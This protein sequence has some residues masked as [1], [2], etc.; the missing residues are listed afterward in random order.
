M[1]ILFISYYNPLGQGGFEKQ[2]RGLLKTL[3]KDG[4]QIACLCVSSG[5]KRSELKS[6]LEATN[7]FSLGV[8]VLSYQEKAY[9]LKTKV[10]F[11]FSSNPVKFLATKHNNLSELLK[12]ELDRI[13]QQSKINYIHCLGLR[14][15]YFIPQ[16]LSIPGTID[17]VDSW[18]Q[19]KARMIN[20]YLRSQLKK[21][22]TAIIDF[23]KTKK[24]EKN[25]L[26]LYGDRYPFAVVS[27]V[28][29]RVLKQLCPK[30]EVHV[31]THPIAIPI[32][33]PKS[34]E[35]SNSNSSRSIVFY[36]FLEQAS[37][38]EALLFLIDKVLPLVLQKYSDLKLKVTGF[39][40]PTKVYEL[41]NNFKWIE[42]LPSI[43]NIGDFLSSATVTCWPFQYGSG[44]KNKI[45]ESMALGKPVVT[46]K[47]GAEALTEKQKQGLLIADRPEDLAKHIIYLLD[48]P[49]ERYQLGK[50]NRQIASTEFTWEQKA[51]D[52][53][54]LYQ[55]S[56]QKHQQNP[57]EV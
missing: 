53:L 51:K 27:S 29:A 20:Y 42:V 37:N 34:V 12:Q 47:I 15:A 3:I 32:T 1:N 33:K 35:G 56:Q 16:Q 55:L 28:D 48:N 38:R 52:Y 41:A 39:N 50:I 14:T 13:S 45:L 11:W 6:Q 19:H 9:S 26:S 5:E 44:F 36:G 57:I 24:I 8:S 10:L 18:T 17:L 25:V 30:A 22:P 2:A 49:Q 7:M 4:H 21:L 46:T 23:F 43:D 54:N 40:I 31:V